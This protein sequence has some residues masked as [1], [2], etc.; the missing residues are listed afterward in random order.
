MCLELWTHINN[1][2]RKSAPIQMLGYG[3][4][5]KPASV[6]PKA[7]GLYSHLRNERKEN[8]NAV[9]SDDCPVSTPLE[10]GC[11]GSPWR[12]DAWAKAAV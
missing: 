6:E 9:S 5:L 7:P 4:L 12:G 2:D 8:Q 1:G 3:I 10:R 11:L